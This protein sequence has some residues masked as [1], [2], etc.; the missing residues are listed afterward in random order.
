MN[1]S[2]S[3]FIRDVGLESYRVAV[4]L[5]RKAFRIGL[6]KHDAVDARRDDVFRADVTG[7][8]RAEERGVLGRPPKAGR[9]GDGS[10][11]G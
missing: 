5:L 6:E 11:H 4:E 2:N 10:P 9:V 1:G 7:E 3:T 8:R